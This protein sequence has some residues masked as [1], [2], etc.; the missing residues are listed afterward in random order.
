MNILVIACI[1]HLTLGLGTRR[2]QDM[3]ITTNLAT[4]HTDKVYCADMYDPAYTLIMC[5][6]EGQEVC[7]YRCPLG[8]PSMRYNHTRGRRC[9]SVCPGGY[10]V[11]QHSGLESCSLHSSRCLPGQ[12]VILPGTT[13]HDTICGD[14]DEYKVRDLTES[15]SPAFH[16]EDVDSQLGTGSIRVRGFY[17]L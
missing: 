13:W 4:C 6:K 17:A 8:Q 7:L 1:L 10:Y 14:P 5:T 12:S 2:T 15:P 16:T 3:W 9:A 11:K